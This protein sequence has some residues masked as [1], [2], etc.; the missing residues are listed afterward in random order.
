[1]YQCARCKAIFPDSLFSAVDM[2][3][4]MWCENEILD[5]LELEVKP[6]GV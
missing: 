3:F 5:E 4:C 6:D 1:M 2:S